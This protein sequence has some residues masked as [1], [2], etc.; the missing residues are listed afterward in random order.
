MSFLILQLISTTISRPVSEAAPAFGYKCCNLGGR[1]G[2][3]SVCEILCGEDVRK[4]LKTLGRS[5][6]W[7]H[8]KYWKRGR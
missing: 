8:Q 5:S 3:H 6:D 1:C 2:S 7:V 4:M